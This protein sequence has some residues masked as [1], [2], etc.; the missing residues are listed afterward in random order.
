MSH[1]PQDPYAAAPGGP[2]PQG[3]PPGGWPAAAAPST[4]YQAPGAPGAPGHGG[5]SDEEENKG[6]AIL[7]Y[8]L[9][10]VP[11]IAGAHK[12]SPFV[13]FHTNQG[14]SL[15]LSAVAISVVTGILSAILTAL[16]F[17]P[18]SWGAAAAGASVIGI[19]WM[20][21]GIAIAVLAIL[22]IVNAAT[23]KTKPLPVI[24]RFNI[25]K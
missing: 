19:L 7:A 25:L 16:L 4:Y 11:L 6:M 9:W 12:K 23:G 13:R 14:I 8:L 18:A 1:T 20:V 5:V 3:S 17:N 2:P 21:V 24:G 22:G 10:F 15:F